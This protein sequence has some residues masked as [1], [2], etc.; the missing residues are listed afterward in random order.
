MYICTHMG[1]LKVIKKKLCK[2]IF[3]VTV[4]SPLLN[5]VA[6]SSPLA[7]PI[8]FFETFR[9]STSPSFLTDSG[10]EQM[11]LDAA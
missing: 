9:Q 2:L 10:A 1:C 7:L 6:I 3:F 11:F 4:V 8:H 5:I